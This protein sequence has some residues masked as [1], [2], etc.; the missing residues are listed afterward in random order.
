[1]PV[2]T[3]PFNPLAYDNL[4]KAVVSELMGRGPFAL[5]PEHSFVGEGV[6]ALF[7]KGDLPWY[8]KVS[9]QDASRPIYVGKASVPGVRKGD[10]SSKPS[11]ALHKRLSEHAESIRCATNL[12]VDDFHCRYLVVD[13]VWISLAEE[14][15]IRHYR[16]VWNCCL[17]GFGNHNPG[18]GRHMGEITWWDALHP[19]RPWAERLQQTKMQQDAIAMVQRFCDGLPDL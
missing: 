15:L 16:P 3:E 13:G 2:E 1:M 9:S 12:D 5:P 17:D 8:A 7:Y 10:T 4:A 14:F 19:G 11:K 18:A 6:Y